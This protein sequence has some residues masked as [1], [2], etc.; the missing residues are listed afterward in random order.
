[1]R[2]PRPPSGKRVATDPPAE[3]VL[4]ESAG[5][6]SRTTYVPPMEKNGAAR[7]RSPSPTPH[8]RSSSLSRVGR[9]PNVNPHGSRQRSA[10]PA[11][12]SRP[13][14]QQ[15]D[16][17]QEPGVSMYRKDTLSPGQGQWSQAGPLSVNPDDQGTDEFCS[18]VPDFTSALHE[19]GA[20]SKMAWEQI[21]LQLTHLLPISEN[22]M[23]GAASARASRPLGSPLGAQTATVTSRLTG[24]DFPTSRRRANSCDPDSP[25]RRKIL[26]DQVCLCIL[27]PRLSMFYGRV[28]KVCGSWPMPIKELNPDTPYTQTHTH[29]AGLPK[30]GSAWVYPGVSSSLFPS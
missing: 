29:I 20:H 21:V 6:Q 11:A 27:R 7:R 26:E 1:M 13:G 5:S 4:A 30:G 10:S 16:R 18:L 24:L 14:T 2:P 8:K 17:D 28:D 19:V 12:P 22:A 15:R 3:D 25:S 9:D 23:D